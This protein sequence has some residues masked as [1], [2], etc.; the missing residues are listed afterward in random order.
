MRWRCLSAVTNQ[1]VRDLSA[2][3]KVDR[4]LPWRAGAFPEAAARD[5]KNSSLILTFSP[6]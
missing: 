2:A 3:T 6:R 1:C 5:A 4:A